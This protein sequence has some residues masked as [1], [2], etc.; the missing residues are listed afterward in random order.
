MSVRK[1]FPNIQSIVDAGI[2]LEHEKKLLDESDD[3]YPQ[4]WLPLQWSFQLS[5]EARAEKYIQADAY[6][7]NIFN[8][9][10]GFQTHLRTLLNYDM[11][12]IPLAYPQVV[13][14]AVR[15]YFIFCLISRQFI[16]NDVP[17]KSQVSLQV[18][19]LQ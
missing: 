4:H 13:F 9:M 16:I 3:E 19:W 18:D 5:V 15:V 12:P 10:C 11:V 14:L 1:R 7:N 8:E 6:I 2:L 17:H